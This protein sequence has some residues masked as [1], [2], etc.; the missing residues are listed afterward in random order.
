MTGVQHETQWYDE[1]LKEIARQQIPVLTANSEKDFK[2]G[3]VVFDVFWPEGNLVGANLTDV[4]ASSIALKII[5]GETAAVLTGDLDLE[6]EEKI[7]KN[8]P[9]LTAQVLKL[10]HHGSRTANSAEF[11]A[12][13]DPD[14]TVV[15]VGEGNSFGHP[16]AEVLERLVNSEILETSKMGSVKLVS[17]GVAWLVK[18]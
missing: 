7:L 14:F 9:D 4:N 16:H 13:V 5:F 11:L 10:G 2:F 18:K 1:I 3:E 17:N 15:S 8:A 12:A 6:S